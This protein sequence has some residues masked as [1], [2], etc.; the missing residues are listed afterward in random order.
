MDKRKW[1][2]HIVDRTNNHP[3]CVTGGFV[4]VCV[5]CASCIGGASL[6]LPLDSLPVVYHWPVK[7]QREKNTH[8]THHP[9]HTHNKTT[10]TS[11]PPFSL[12]FLPFLFL[13]FFCVYIYSIYSSLFTWLDSF[14]KKNSHL[15]LSS[16]IDSRR[17]SKYTTHPYSL[18]RRTYLM[19]IWWIVFLRVA[20][21]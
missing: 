21:A 3:R 9:A 16:D 17:P 12:S 15:T 19:D 11:S 5:Q 10:T 7:I 2:R 6:T 4:W 8:H 1:R 20:V 14:N 18:E 13:F